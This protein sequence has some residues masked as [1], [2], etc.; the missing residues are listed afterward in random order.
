[1]TNL[2]IIPA[3]GGSK[4]I[5]RKNLQL[6]AGL[7]L[8]CWTIKAATSSLAI[9]KVIVS[10]DDEEIAEVSSDFG[11]EVPFIR[12]ADISADES[13][14]L[15][16]CRHALEFFESDS[17]FEPNNIIYL[18]P[19]SPFR[20]ASHIDEAMNFFLQNNADTLVSVM[21]VPHNMLPSSQV[22]FDQEIDDFIQ[23]ENSN[24]FRRQ[25]KN[26]NY[27]ARNGPAILIST[28]ET[29]LQNQLYGQKV[30]VFEMGT[31]S[32]FDIDEP[33]DLE[34]AECLFPLSELSQ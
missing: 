3:R 23:I 11:A 9:D 13:S 7:P 34:I 25:N 14:A 10:T 19:T 5:P 1:M 31:I 22:Y 21:P 18:Q 17:D 15:D 28:V 16:V 27:Y 33:I 12:P 20:K 2:A 6:L 32:S 4:G 26:K 24:N 29:I 30:S 8:V